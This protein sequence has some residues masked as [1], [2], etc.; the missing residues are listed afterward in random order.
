MLFCVIALVVSESP[1]ILGLKVKIKRDDHLIVP[2][3]GAENI[4]LGENVGELS[5][6]YKKDNYRIVK[7]DGENNLLQHVFKTSFR[8]KIMFDE[9]YYFEGRKIIIMIREK[10]VVSVLSMNRQRV[11]IDSV[12]LHLGV[13]N[14]IKAYKKNKFKKYLSNDNVLY[15]CRE[16]GIGI[17]DDGN[18]DVVDMYYVFYPNKGRRAK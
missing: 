5:K 11:T 17:V 7:P 12:D 8:K 1:V 18:D 2:G 10:I 9:M 4:L 3:F 15:N 16:L 13:E 14:F 6:Q